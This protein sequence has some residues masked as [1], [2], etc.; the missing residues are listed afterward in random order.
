MSEQLVLVDVFDNQ[1]GSGEK[2]FVHQKG[3]L[4]RAFSVFLFNGS[5]ML[6]QQRALNKYHSGGLWANACCSHP[7]VDEE[8]FEA[9][10]R[11]LVEE[12]GVTCGVE[13]LF[14]FVYRSVFADGLIEYELDHVFVGEYAGKFSVN[15]QEVEQLCFVETIA[16]AERLT[17]HPEEFAPWFLIAAPSVIKKVGRYNI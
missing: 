10:S 13:E 15:P 14:S 8:L 12:I 3:L 4:H 2:L 16:L 9:V 11:R 6:I 1:I 7:R 5:K 17:S